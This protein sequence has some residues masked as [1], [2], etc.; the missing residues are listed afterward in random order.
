MNAFKEPV[1]SETDEFKRVVSKTLV[2]YAIIMEDIFNNI[3]MFAVLNSGFK[4]HTELLKNIL[5][6]LSE[7]KQ[8]PQL[9]SYIQNAYDQFDERYRRQLESF[10]RHLDDLDKL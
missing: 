4:D 3:E 9:Q 7:V 1:E 8:N 5:A 2:K 10:S 6:Q